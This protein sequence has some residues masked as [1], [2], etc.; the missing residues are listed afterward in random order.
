M[1][2]I[3]PF[4]L[5]A[6][7]CHRERYKT[8]SKLILGTKRGHSRRRKRKKEER[9]SRYP[10]NERYRRP[11]LPLDPVGPSGDFT[12]SASEVA[13]LGPSLSEETLGNGEPDTLSR[14]DAW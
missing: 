4:K 12:F 10:V 14:L 3:V 11:N 13:G 9:D 2:K 6:S 7:F 8:Y 1:A 5:L